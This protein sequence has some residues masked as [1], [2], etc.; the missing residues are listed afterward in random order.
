VGHLSFQQS[1]GCVCYNLVC[2]THMCLICSVTVELSAVSAVLC[3]VHYTHT[4]NY[5]FTVDGVK[6]MVGIGQLIQLW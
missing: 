1:V 4:Q 6:Q 5:A 2:A 3:N